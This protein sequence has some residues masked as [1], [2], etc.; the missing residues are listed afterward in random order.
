MTQGWRNAGFAAGW[1]GVF[2]LMGPVVGS[3]FFVP[4]FGPL[5]LGVGIV[6]GAP[7]AIA[8]GVLS[9]PIATFWVRREL[10]SPL[11]M[12]L[13][14]FL[15]GAFGPIG[16]TLARQ[17]LAGGR[18]NLDGLLLEIGIGSLAGTGC[19]A[20]ANYA[21]PKS[22]NARASAFLNSTY[23]SHAARLVSSILTSR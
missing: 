7:Y 21:S 23:S 10:R 11:R 17:G 12:S 20:L 6:L 13:L 5:A 1:V 19:A 9:A 15:S 3:L 14:G 8:A 16:V 2:A 4:L 22:S 18:E